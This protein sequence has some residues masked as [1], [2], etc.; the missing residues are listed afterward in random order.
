LIL[1]VATLF[2]F[3]IQIRPKH[4]DTIETY[5]NHAIHIHTP[6]EEENEGEHHDHEGE[7]HSAYQPINNDTPHDEDIGGKH[8]M[9]KDDAQSMQFIDIV[10]KK[11]TYYFLII[12]FFSGKS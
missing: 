4:R 3:F 11:E 10:K 12:S 7:I 5:S 9:K 8:G 6:N 1:L 2:S